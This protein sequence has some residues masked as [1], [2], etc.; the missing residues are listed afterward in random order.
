[1]TSVILCA[2]GSGTRMESEVPKQFLLLGDQPVMTYSFDLFCYMEEIR[3]V[4]VVCPEN[5]R[6]LFRHEKAIFADP[7]NRRQDSVYNGLL[8]ASHDLICV[9]DGARPF[10]TADIIRKALKTAEIM[11]AVA[12]GVPLPFTIKEKNEA[13]FVLGTPDRE[14]FWEI[15]TPQVMRRDLLLE[16]FHWANQRGLTV[17]D[18]VRLVELI[19]H[20]VKLIAGSSLNLKLTRPEDLVLAQALLPRYLKTYEQTLQI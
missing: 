13:G 7:G 2:G 6:H 20:P 12:V 10:I 4:I 14:K 18:D 17:T 19:D 1:M 8:K 5:Y 15:Q 9:H 11:G 16:G 3:E